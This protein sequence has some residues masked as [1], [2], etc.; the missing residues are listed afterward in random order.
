ALE[1]DLERPGLREMITARNLCPLLSRPHMR[2]AAHA[3]ALDRHDDPAR[4]WERARRLAPYDP[5]LWYY[6]GV[7]SRKQGRTEEAW[8]QW[9]RSLTLSRK[10]LP[11]ILDAALAAGM[12]A[13]DML[14]RLLPDDPLVL[15]ETARKLEPNPDTA[16]R[17]RSFWQRVLE[18]L[19]TR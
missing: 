4:Y 14:T 8:A 2:L 11:P 3:A 19:R 1:E 15:F 6:S 16:E 10:Y 13:N 17:T 7:E 5:E 18:L 12:S 9:K